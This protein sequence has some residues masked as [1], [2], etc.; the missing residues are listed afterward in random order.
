MSHMLNVVQ[1]ANEDDGRLA[2]GLDLSNELDDADLNGDHEEDFPLP[3]TFQTLARGARFT[4]RSSSEESSGNG[5]VLVPAKDLKRPKGHPDGPT[6]ATSPQKKRVRENPG[7]SPPPPIAFALDSPVPDHKLGGEMPVLVADIFA[8]GQDKGN[9]GGCVD[10]KGGAADGAK[11]AKD[12]T[13]QS[14]LSKF[15]KVHSLE[16][17]QDHLSR[18]FEQMKV[19]HEAREVRD[20]EKRRKEKARTRVADRERQQR[21]RDKEWKE[22][23]AGG[24]IPGQ[25]RVSTIPG[26]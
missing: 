16:E 4:F 23:V 12:H 11:T 5:V 21:H 1:I 2:E 24:W 26:C 6:P 17:K 20:V 3:K 7:N 25:K 15:W 8:A 10:A 9:K 14:K 22:R 13:Q 18:H 19:D